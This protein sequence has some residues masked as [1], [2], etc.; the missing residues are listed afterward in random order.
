MTKSR[1]AAAF[2]TALFLSVGLGT[3]SAQS[4]AGAQASPAYKYS[5]P[6]APGVA[7]PDKLESS[8]GTLDLHYGYPE[9]GT[10]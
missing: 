4:V 5:A 10:R 9:A 2:A 1:V 8:I 3:A 7:V 6:I